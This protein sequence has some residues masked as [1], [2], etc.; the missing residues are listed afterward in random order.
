MR[1][2]DLDHLALMALRYAMGRMSTAPS[3]CADALRSV[4]ERLSPGYRALILRDLREALAEDD[5]RRDEGIMGP[6]LNYRLGMDCDRDTW[7]ALLLDLDA[8]DA[9]RRTT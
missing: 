5:R 8:A 4:W 7:R 2:T 9:A 3:D 1:A 6:L